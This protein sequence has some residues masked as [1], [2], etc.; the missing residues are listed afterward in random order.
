[1]DAFIEI[2][3]AIYGNKVAYLTFK[4]KESIGV[5]IN[6]KEISDAEKS[7]FEIM[8]NNSKK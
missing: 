7:L 3:K 1:M 4:E 6:N 8:W 5:L 2:T